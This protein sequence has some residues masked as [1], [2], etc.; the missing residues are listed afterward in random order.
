MYYDARFWTP[1]DIFHR[2][3]EFAGLVVLGTVVLY[4]RPVLIL[5]DPRNNVDMFCLSLSLAIAGAMA[6]GR[7]AELYYFGLGQPALKMAAKRDFFAS[8]IIVCWYTA[9]AI[10]SGTEYYGHLESTDSYTKHSDMGD[11]SGYGYA[12]ESNATG[13]EED[14]HRGLAGSESSYDSDIP[15]YLVLGGSMTFL[16]TTIVSVLALPGG[17]KHKE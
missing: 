12:D 17:G 10:V 16:V 8:T 7:F 9:A 15:I 2:M 6:C 11:A 3:Y 14:H 1:D 13:Y 4:I 5:S